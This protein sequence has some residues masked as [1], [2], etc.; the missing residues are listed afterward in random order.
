MKEKKKKRLNITRQA[1]DNE[2]FPQFT[3]EYCYLMIKEL[4]TLYPTGTSLV[5]RL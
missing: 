1:T 5:V 3:H 4:C 2:F